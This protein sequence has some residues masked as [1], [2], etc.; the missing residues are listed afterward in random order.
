VGNLHAGK[1]NTFF[2]YTDEHA[3]GHPY[4]TSYEMRAVALTGGMLCFNVTHTFYMRSLGFCA[5]IFIS[6]EVAN[7]M[8]GSDVVLKM[9]NMVDAL[10]V[11]VVLAYVHVANDIAHRELWVSTNTQQE[12]QRDVGAATVSLEEKS[13]FLKNTEKFMGVVCNMV[14]R[15]RLDPLGEIVEHSPT[16]TEMFGDGA[17]L[18]SC[19]LGD[20]RD[21]LRRFLEQCQRAQEGN[22]ERLHTTWWSTCG[23]KLDC[24]VSSTKIGL[25]EALIGL[26]IHRVTDATTGAAESIV[27]GQTSKGSPGDQAAIPMGMDADT[28]VADFVTISIQKAEVLT[29]VEDVDPRSGS[30]P[31]LRSVPLTGSVVFKS[32]ARDPGMI[33]VQIR[34]RD[35]LSFMKDVAPEALTWTALSIEKSELVREGDAAIGKGG[36]A[37]VYKD[38]F[39]SS[40]VAVKEIKGTDSQ[41][42]RLMQKELSHLLRMRHRSIVLIMGAAFDRDPDGITMTLSIVMEL[43]EGG[44]VASRIYKEKDM[45]HAAGLVILTQVAEALTFLHSFNI[46]HRD[47]KAGNALLATRSLED[48]LAKLAD[49]GASLESVAGRRSGTLVGTEGY[50]APEQYRGAQNC[51]VDIYAFGMFGYEVYAMKNPFEDALPHLAQMRDWQPDRDQKALRREGMMHLSQM[52]WTPDV[53]GIDPRVKKLLTACWN[54]QQ[55]KRPPMRDVLMDLRSLV[56]A[57]ADPAIGVDH[58]SSPQ[59]SERAHGE[60]WYI[61]SFS[62]RGTLPW[63]CI[64]YQKYSI[65]GNLKPI[66]MKF[67]AVFS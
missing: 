35:L 50:M 39:R 20:E 12:L 40:F 49:F 25:N 21:R 59:R 42:M 48:P 36:F 64:Y 65:L 17:Y 67:E 9:I 22:C 62:S 18:F 14:L 19:A 10:A 29:A 54:L 51:A 26:I 13:R 16:Y 52:G 56:H 57:T 63:V 31:S 28:F 8:D 1:Y 6:S 7:S 27:D 60:S 2:Q 3:G 32:D 47:V 43:C 46:V 5:I 61:F 41:S 11:M 24:T 15:L 4:T 55:K 53:W 34:Q 58:S 38:T 44:S 45:T 33:D 66:S 30:D 37:T 23:T